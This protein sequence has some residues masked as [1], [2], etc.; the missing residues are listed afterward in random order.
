[1]FID[2]CQYRIS[3]ELFSVIVLLIVVCWSVLDWSID[4]AANVANF[5]A[6]LV[7]PENYFDGNY[8]KKSSSRIRKICIVVI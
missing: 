6:L 1:M 3:N 5:V 8:S 2:S 4:G 7:V